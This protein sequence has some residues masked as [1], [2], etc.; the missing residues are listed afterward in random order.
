MALDVAA[1]LSVN[2][3]VHLFFFPCGASFDKLLGAGFVL[4]LVLSVFPPL[5]P[6]PS[7][8]SPPCITHRAVKQN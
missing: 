2:G 3:A 1:P 8:P 7:F 5:H 4:Q 6:F